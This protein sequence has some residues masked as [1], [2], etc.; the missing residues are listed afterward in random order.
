VFPGRA[1]VVVPVPSLKPFPSNEEG[2][3]SNPLATPLAESEHALS[4]PSVSIAVTLATYV[5]P[6]AS[7]VMILDTVCPGAGVVVGDGTVMNDALGQGGVEVARYMRKP[8]RSVTGVPSAFVVGAS[9]FTVTDAASTRAVATI[10]PARMS[11]TRR[12]FKR[13]LGTVRI[14]PLVALRKQQCAVKLPRRHSVRH[15]WAM[16]QSKCQMCKCAHNQPR[17]MRDVTM[18]ACDVSATRALSQLRDAVFRSHA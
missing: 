13:H 16:W 4:L 14:G 2:A 8:A 15:P 9:Q 6:A 18:V 5:V 7:P 12:D 17:T 11:P 1:A 10:L 3:V